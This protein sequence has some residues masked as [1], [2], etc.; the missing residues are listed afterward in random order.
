MSF[1]LF[2]NYEKTLKHHIMAK[3]LFLL[4]FIG[5][6]FYANNVDISGKVTDLEG[7]GIP[8]VVVSVEGTTISTITDI[9]GN[10]VL[11]NVPDEAK[12]IVF[13]MIGMETQTIKIKDRTEINVELKESDAEL[14]EV[15]VSSFGISS[16]KK[17]GGIFSRKKDRSAPKGEAVYHSYGGADYDY[18][19]DYGGG[20]DN[21]Q[22]IASGQLTAGEV[23]DF[24]KWEMWQDI[25]EDQL[26]Q[27]REVW[28]MYP[29]QRYS[30]LLTSE[31]NKPIIDANVYL[32]NK[33][34]TIWTAKTDN[35][36]KAELWANMFDST[37]LKNISIQIDYRGNINSIDN[38]T[39]FHNG[40]NRVIIDTKC[41]IPD[42]VDIAFVIDAT[43]SMSDEMS[44][45]QAEILDVI[46]RIDTTHTDLTVNLGSVLYRDEGDDYLAINK[47]FTKNIGS[48]VDYIKEQRTGGGGDFPEAV[49]AAMEMAIN[50]LKWSQDA[51]TRIIFLVLDAPPH[52]DQEV[53]EKL[54]KLTQ[55]AAEK[56]I[57]IVPITCSGVDKSTEY[58]MR[59]MALATN[60][61]YVFLTDDSGIGGS[62]IKPTTDEWEVEFLN[63]LIV[64]LVNQYVVT[65]TCNNQIIVDEQ[66]LQQDTVLVNFPDIDTNLVFVDTNVVYIDTVQI[67]ADSV[68]IDTSGISNINPFLVEET[69]KI[70]PNPTKGD[71]TIEITGE[72]NEFYVC[73]FSGKILERH[74]IDRR[75]EVKLFIGTYPP[76]IY[77]VRYF[78]GERLE[79]GKVVLMY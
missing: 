61:T 75:S 14:D 77:F 13:S 57:R 71:L 76:G 48:A 39:S 10:Y 37:E 17:S 32:K 54:Q 4:A 52:N 41:D 44:Y 19:D 1:V 34:E 42:I 66:D 25:T 7:L 22:Q 12:K 40:I 3:I 2:V 62:H 27:Y 46:N 79:S 78:V 35:T 36:G 73:D 50:D 74:E 33:N 5:V 6:L 51:R 60:G 31:D 70:Y 45:L 28:Q 43:S 69:L 30:V 24:G 53:V 29:K 23:N 64:R 15:V 18:S 56:G 16:E 47:N 65:P 49:D 59:S 8:G 67:V 38:P 21:N 26:K 55:K 9:G 20:V 58:L 11:K 72:I 63:D 68:I